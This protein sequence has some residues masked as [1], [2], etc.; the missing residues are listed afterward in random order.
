ME[1]TNKNRPIHSTRLANT[2]KLSRI[3]LSLIT[4][5][6]FC[7]LAVSGLSSNSDAQT[8]PTASE[9]NR[10]HPGWVQSPGQLISP[11]CVHE[12]PK[13]ALVELTSDGQISGDV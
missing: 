12:I 2:P 13:G 4:T 8:S 11:D 5:A 10:A 9:A 3:G 7:C 1:P 6:I